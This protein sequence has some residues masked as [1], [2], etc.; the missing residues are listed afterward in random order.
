MTILDAIGRTCHRDGIDRS[1]DRKQRDVKTQVRSG[2]PVIVNLRSRGPVHD[3]VV[4]SIQ[5]EMMPM[6][7]FQ[8]SS[9]RPT[10]YRQAS[11]KTEFGRASLSPQI[12][13]VGL[14]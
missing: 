13:V 1:I 8:V 2:R 7:M 6:M 4:Q 9:Y 5:Y 11:G 10:W 14:E 3:A 12:V